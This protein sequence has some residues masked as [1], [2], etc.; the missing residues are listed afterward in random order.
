MVSLINGDIFMEVIC[1][2]YKQCEFVD[3]CEHAKPHN[4]IHIIGRG[5]ANSCILK[6]RIE[7]FEGRFG[8]SICYCSPI[9]LR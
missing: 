9:F 4:I 2:N 6:E 3:T 7:I 1:K 8:R 5:S